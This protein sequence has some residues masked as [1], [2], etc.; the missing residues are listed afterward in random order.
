VGD[1]IVNTALNVGEDG[2]DSGHDV[3]FYGHELGSRMFWVHDKQ[4]LRA[5]RDQG[6]SAWDP[7]SVGK[8]SIG[9]G[10]DPK[11]KGESS[12]A[13]GSFTTAG[14][15]Y[16]FTTGKIV[17]A[18]GDF[19]IGIG[20]NAYALGTHSLAIGE[21]VRADTAHAMVIGSGA[22]LYLD[23]LVNSIENSLMVGFNST[24]PLLFVGGP[25]DR[26]GVRTMYPTRVFAVGQTEGYPIADG[27]TNYSSRRWKENITS[28]SGALDKVER[29]QGV[30]FDWKETG[31][32][33]MGLIAED[34]GEIVPEVVIYEDNGVDAE[35]ID[36]ARL[37]A[38]LIEAVKEQQ[39]EIETL[40]NEVDQMR[41]N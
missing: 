8:Y 34:V 32:H 4:A 30:Y 16:S 35:S 23:E 13:F 10:L 3:N 12:V 41:V 15:D 26:V 27:W 29:L 6:Y 22:G 5:G 40:K 21:N 28:I 36:Y 11:A 31:H 24:E 7:D 14:G 19:S 25:S 1:L 2:L 17:S 38:L 20:E 37:V 18:N 33:D 39:T 9:M